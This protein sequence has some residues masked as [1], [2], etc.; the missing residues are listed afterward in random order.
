MMG[1]GKSN[2]NICLGKRKQQTSLVLLDA[3]TPLAAWLMRAVLIKK[4]GAGTHAI[5]PHC[6]SSAEENRANAALLTQGDTQPL[7]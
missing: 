3:L 5:T 2:L 1:E 4:M 7:P 6:L